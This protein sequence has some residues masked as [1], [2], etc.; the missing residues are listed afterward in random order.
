MYRFRPSDRKYVAHSSLYILF[1][2]SSSLYVLFYI[3]SSL[4]ILFYILYVCI[5]G[6]CLVKQF[7]VKILIVVLSYLFWESEAKEEKVNHVPILRYSSFV[8]PFV[9]DKSVQ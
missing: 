9:T 5:L 2:I 1:Y 8:M 7:Q 6:K 4:Y 3:Y